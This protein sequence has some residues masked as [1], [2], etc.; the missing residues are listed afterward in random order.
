MMLDFNVLITHGHKFFME[1]LHKL[2]YGPNVSHNG[3]KKEAL[4]ILEIKKI[5]NMENLVGQTRVST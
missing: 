4:K 2:A 1:E 3:C 5:Y